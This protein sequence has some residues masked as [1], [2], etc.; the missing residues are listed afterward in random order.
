MEEMNA[1]E[2]PRIV[3][4]GETPIKVHS[5]SQLHNAL[6]GGCTEQPLVVAI[7]SVVG[8][9]SVEERLAQLRADVDKLMKDASK[10][11]KVKRN[12]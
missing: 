5:P 4:R 6:A 3:Y 7:E 12:G 9:E 10:G 2:F 11:E 8:G 1:K